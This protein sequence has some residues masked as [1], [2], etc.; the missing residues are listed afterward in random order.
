MRNILECSVKPHTC[1]GNHAGVATLFLSG[2]INF[3][4][5]GKLLA[6]D[7]NVLVFLA[8][9]QRLLFSPSMFIPPPP[10]SFYYM[11]TDKSKHA[12]QPKKNSKPGVFILLLSLSPSVLLLLLWPRAVLLFSLHGIVSQIATSGTVRGAIS[13]VDEWWERRR[14]DICQREEEKNGLAEVLLKIKLSS[15]RKSETK[16]P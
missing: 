14:S 1:M 15:R 10:A 8:S 9:Y 4:S 13:T 2:E 5:E 3:W 16:T 6:K 12:T 7:E 11:H